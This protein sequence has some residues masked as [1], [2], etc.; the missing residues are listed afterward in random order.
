MDARQNKLDYEE[1]R[2]RVISVAQQKVQMVKPTPMDV[3]VIW[4]SSGRH[5]GD[6]GS[7][8]AHKGDMR[9]RGLKK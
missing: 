1:C 9:G 5:L 7:P 8:G 3:G 4:E 6:L 2:D